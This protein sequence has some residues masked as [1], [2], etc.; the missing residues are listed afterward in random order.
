MASVKIKVSLGYFTLTILAALMV[1]VTYSEIL[2]YSTE[3]VDLNPVNNKF[4][5]INN[6]LTNLYQAEGLERN[7][8]QTRQPAQYQNYLKLMDT[9]SSQIDTLTL[10]VNSPIQQMH[11][12]SIKKLLLVKQQNL[13]ELSAIKKTNSSTARYQQALNK[14][15]VSKDSI[16]HYMTVYRNVST[17]HDTVY[18]KQKKRKFFERL[19]NVFAAQ[20]KTDSNLRVQTIHSVRV[21][22]LIDPVNPVDTIA[23]F[24]TS[25]MNEIRNDSIAIDSRLKLKER[26][27]LANDRTISMQLRQMLTNIENE[28]LSNSFQKVR[29]QQSRVEKKTWLIILV[30]GFALVTIIFFLVNILRDITKSQHYRKSLEEEKAYTELLLKSKEHFMLSLTHDLKS[31]LSSI[32]GFTGIMQDEAGVSPRHQKYLQNISKSSSHILNLINSLLDLARLQTG[33]LTIDC[34]P[35]SLKP[36][37]DDVVE[38]FRPQAI[39]KNIDLQFQFNLPPTVVYVSDP[40]R[41]TQVLSNLISNAF[42]FT[43]TGKI[44]IFVSTVKSAEKIDQVKIEVID[45]GIG[46][47]K[48]NTRRIFEEFARVASPRQHEGTGLG[49]TITQ[50]L[51]HLL[52]GTINLESKVGEGSHFTIVLPLV[53]GEQLAVLTPQITVDQSKKANAGITGKKV[54]LID[55]DETLLEMTSAILNSAGMA[56]HAFSD[57]GIAIRSFEKGCADLLITDIQMPNINGVEVL[58][59]ILIKNGGQITAIAVS[60]KVLEENELAGFSAFV[61]KPFLPQTLINAIS[62]QM[63]EGTAIDNLKDSGNSRHNGYNLNQFTAFAEGDPESLRQILVSF[64][65]TGKQ[66]ALLFRQYLQDESDHELSEL[67]HKMLSLFR[68]LEAN[69]LVGLLSQMEHKDFASLHR[70]EFYSCGKL[71]IDKI[72]ALLQTIQ[73]EENI[74][75]G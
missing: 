41:I 7:Y 50:K 24:I 36:L 66:N 19:A 52:K 25:V 44:S 42:K 59:Q 53:K 69:D 68:Q 6:I 31:P 9:I 11:T 13:K 70:K 49:L 33:K 4:I 57:P 58:K 22:S 43:E 64:I 30:G 73:K 12:D 39:A 75:I 16:S 17:N 38:G 63:K 10:M 8:V 46:I 61:Q 3:K 71:A 14:L 18:V 45:T 35:F 40:M 67:S 74:Y 15:I 48:E 2:L 47:S 54:W 32:I 62:G 72:D 27:I 29:E 26:E 37:M 56:V 1:W 60:G 20:N 28:E 55:D 51:I 5:Y 23:S 34:I 21:D 65:R